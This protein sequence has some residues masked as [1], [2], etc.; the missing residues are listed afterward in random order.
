M[1]WTLDFDG[2]QLLGAVADF[3]NT[4]MTQWTREIGGGKNPFALDS[5]RI[6]AA[7]GDTQASLR[8]QGNEVIAAEEEIRDKLLAEMNTPAGK[9]AERL[10]RVVFGPE[11]TMNKLLAE[12][13]FIIDRYKQ[14]FSDGAL[15]QK[16][17]AIRVAL[18]S[19]VCHFGTRDTTEEVIYGGAKRSC[20]NEV[21]Q[22]RQP[23]AAEPALQDSTGLQGRSADSAVQPGPAAAA[24]PSAAEEGAESEPPPA[25]SAVAHGAG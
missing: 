15:E 19:L 18:M 6:D 2:L 11:A 5:T 21:E 9:F 12:Q 7:I 22:Q 1:R 16:G 17:N 24:V 23:V 14:V 3:L 10:T 20:A 13:N 4:Y 8:K 25:E